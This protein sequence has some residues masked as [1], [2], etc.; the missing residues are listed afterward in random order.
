MK[1]CGSL[2][3]SYEISSRVGL[4]GDYPKCHG[5]RLRHH[6][7]LT[8]FNGDHKRRWAH[9]RLPQIPWLEAK[10]LR[11]LVEPKEISNGDGLADDC[12]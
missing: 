7:R 3:E 4:V 11:G 10:A 8:E 2:A 6:V 1:R 9:R 5:L 12:P